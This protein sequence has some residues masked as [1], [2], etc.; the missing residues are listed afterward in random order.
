MVVE[1]FSRKRRACERAASVIQTDEIQALAGVE[2]RQIEN[3]LIGER[4]LVE[5]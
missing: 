3:V 5:R 1:R 4:V 2:F